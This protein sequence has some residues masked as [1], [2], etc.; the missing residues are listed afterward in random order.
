[1]T[2]INKIISKIGECVFGLS[3]IHIDVKEGGEIVTSYE[4][5]KDTLAIIPLDNYRSKIIE[6]D[7][8]FIV[9]KTPLQVVEESC[10]YFGSSYQGRH[11]GTEIL[12]GITH[13]SPIIIEESREIIFFPTS[14]PK[15]YDCAWI[16]FKNVIKHSRVKNSCVIE[17]KSGYLLEVDVSYGSLEN[18]ILRAARLESVLRDRKA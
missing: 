17:F 11:R 9:D 12:T 13:K 4:I 18:Q 8:I 14:S 6:K 7:S 15:L 16:S 5:T 3:K 2:F 10:E 1:M